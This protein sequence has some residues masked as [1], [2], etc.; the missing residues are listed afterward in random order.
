LS[1]ARRWDLTPLE[2][3]DYA[4]TTD[5][6]PPRAPDAELLYHYTAGGSRILKTAVDK[7]GNQRHTAYIFTSLELRSA[8]Y[9][10]LAGDYELTTD[11]V[12]LYLTSG[13]GRLAEVVHGKSDW[14]ALQSGS[15]RLFH[16]FADYL[17][18]TNTLIDH[19]TGELVSKTTYSAYGLT[20]SDYRPGRWGEFRENY[21]FTGKE[22]D[23]EVGLTYFGAR[24]YAPHLGTWCSADPVTIHEL[25]SDMNP[26]SYVGGRVTTAVDPNGEEIFT[27]IAIGVA[28]GAVLG[29]ASSAVVQGTT[30]GFDNINWGWSGVLGGAAGGAVAGGLTAGLG[31]SLGAG[32]SGWV[33]A[34]L[35]NAGG[36]ATSTAL[37][38]GKPGDIASAAVW[39]S[40]AGAAG[41]A[42][43][44]SLN[45]TLLG[46]LEPTGSFSLSNAT[47][48]S[49]A[50]SS[51]LS[52]VGTSM[53]FEGFRD[54]V[55]PK[56]K[57]DYARAAAIGA[58]SGA[59]SYLAG[60]IQ[61]NYDTPV[62]HGSREGA[63][64]EA[65]SQSQTAVNEAYNSG[66]P[67]SVREYAAFVFEWGGAYY[68]AP[69]V[70][71]DYATMS[72]S[73]FTDSSTRFPAGATKVS[74][75]HGHPPPSGDELARR[76]EQGLSGGPGTYNH[77]EGA[78]TGDVSA[79]ESNRSVYSRG[80]PWVEAV[81]APDG[82]LEFI[83]PGR[84][85]PVVIQPAL[86]G[87]PAIRGR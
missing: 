83:Y 13:G 31:S 57:A 71:Q 29:G 78:H 52:G 59:G 49:G 69:P 82:H 75:A 56:Y 10:P 36:A 54:F 15:V 51:V 81:S 33:A 3:S 4:A 1:R 28:I 14:P 86:R 47:H 60:A 48:L 35:G 64:R 12:T 22:D 62:A 74:L 39:G 16:L 61:G 63:L 50:A 46:A 8:Q 85:Q 53:A 38:G 66:L 58:G 79:A 21:R 84:S 27:A 25:G 18:S 11:T 41:S 76:A 24:Y 42:L 23:I 68:A 80:G 26:Y 17:G 87:I 72:D 32:L 70:R 20:E 6:H 37:A 67:K 30:K 77:P 34:G 55:S 5:A 9:Q 43:T 7:N 19:S 2:L 40:V 45:N 73:E 44:P 65:A